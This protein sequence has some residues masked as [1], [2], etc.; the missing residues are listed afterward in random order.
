MTIGG[1]E[2]LREH[3]GV[4]GV[5]KA[6]IRGEIKLLQQCVRDV[7]SEVDIVAAEAALRREE[8]ILEALTVRDLF[9]MVALE[10]VKTRH[11]CISSA[12]NEA[13]QTA[14]QMISLRKDK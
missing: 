1:E 14:D 2:L 13:S 5:A 7:C 3:G 12:V 6:Y 8:S 4:Q 9:M 10:C 11:S